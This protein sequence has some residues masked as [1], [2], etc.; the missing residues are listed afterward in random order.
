MHTENSALPE[1]TPAPVSIGRPWVGWCVAAW[2]VI[3]LSWPIQYLTA[4]MEWSKIGGESGNADYTVSYAL[5]SA[6]GGTMFTFIIVSLF[7]LARSLRNKRSFFK[8]TFWVALSLLGVAL[9][10][11]GRIGAEKSSESSR[12]AKVTDE[13]F[14]ITLP[15]RK[16][17]PEK[18][19][20]GNA[21]TISYTCTTR[22]PRMFFQVSSTGPGVPQQIDRA[23][24]QLAGEHMLKTFFTEGKIV[25]SEQLKDIKGYGREFIFSGKD[26]K[27]S[28][29][30]GR[31]RIFAANGYLFQLLYLGSDKAGGQ[32]PTAK[33]VFG[34]F[35]LADPNKKPAIP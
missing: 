16:P 34:T 33:S 6:L 30:E 31:F 35:K 22:N 19:A 9:S 25:S 4:T 2:S 7:M 13:Q 18:R 20:Q 29:G 15:C 26:G 28:P 11:L 3:V 32:L 24:V 5:G 14:S 1:N 27:D 23:K 21:T 10:K 8:I 12:V 17:T